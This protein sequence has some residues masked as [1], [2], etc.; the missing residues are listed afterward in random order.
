MSSPSIAIVG[1]DIGALMLA[2]LLHLADIPV[3]VYECESQHDSNTKGGSLQLH[4]VS[5]QL[6]IHH[7]QLSS[8][9]IMAACAEGGGMRIADKTGNIIH[10]DV[11]VES[12][13]L[14]VDP[15]QLRKI[16]LE[17]IP[18]D[19]VMRDSAVQN[20]KSIADDKHIIE[21]KT[22]SGV[23][24]S[25]PFDLIVGADGAWSKVRPL[26]SEIKPH[27]STIS[28]FDFCNSSIDT[29]YPHFS[30]MV[31]QGTYIA[32][33]DRKCIISQ[34]NSDGSLHIQTMIQARETW[35]HDVSRSWNDT[36]KL[37]IFLA[38]EVYQDWDASLRDLIRLANPD[39][40]SRAL[41]MLSID[42]QWMTKPGFTL[43]GDAAHLMTPFASES[44]D[45][46]MLDALELSQAITRSCGKLPSS[47]KY[48]SEGV[49]FG[50]SG[51]IERIPLI[52]PPTLF[53]AIEIYEDG[54][55]ER[56]RER[57]REAWHNL[58]LLFQSDAPRGF[59]AQIET[60]RLQVEGVEVRP[61]DLHS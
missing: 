5:G 61:P 6:A 9:L 26:L 25:K 33:S 41:Y 54:M 43:M 55:M 42:F 30:A 16:L 52:S 14:E 47:I 2:H 32:A 31:S 45:L 8:D 19:A 3:M 44:V 12:D 1:A 51:S 50:D 34:R 56:G 60:M 39:P 23:E 53:E 4:T 15:I 11:G 13:K 48:P 36:E 40:A 10:E 59:V 7:A 18:P 24:T 37:K 28:T 27:Y 17:S 21:F 46:A 49:S 38:D 29:S 20:I 35:L 57:M 22:T 58:E